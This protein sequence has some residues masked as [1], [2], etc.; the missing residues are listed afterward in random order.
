MLV[1]CS[2]CGQGVETLINRPR[3]CDKCKKDNRKMW[4]LKN[5]ESL[6]NYARDWVHARRWLDGADNM[7]GEI[8]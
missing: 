4:V 6:N 7:D 2:K 1:E 5:R 3:T 8:G